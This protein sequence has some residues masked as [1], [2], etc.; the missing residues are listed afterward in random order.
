MH[1]SA[2]DSRSRALLNPT[3]SF[4]PS[5]PLSSCQ[6]TFFMSIT[7]ASQFFQTLA[8]PVLSPF[9]SHPS[10]FHPPSDALW[11][12][13]S[14]SSC[15][16]SER[17]SPAFTRRFAQ[18]LR[19]LTTPPLTDPLSDP[20]EYIWP[21]ASMV[22]YQS[23][24]YLPYSTSSSSFPISAPIFRPRAYSP[25]SYP[26]RHHRRPCASSLPHP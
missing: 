19:S 16:L 4:N 21:A 26:D 24:A 10:P 11:C 2:F 23:L 18:G 7:A 13:I 6:H 22:C 5:Y 12:S 25:S 1:T 3:H 15:M 14:F 9:A 20:M 17:S 8:R